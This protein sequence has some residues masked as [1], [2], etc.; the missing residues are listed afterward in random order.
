MAVKP[1]V[2]KSKAKK[3]G[4][5]IGSILKF[6]ESQA[7]GQKSKD[8]FQEAADIEVPPMGAG[9]DMFGLGPQTQ[10]YAAKAGKGVEALAN[11]GLGQLFGTDSAYNLGKPKQSVASGSGNLAN[12]LMSILP[13]G[14]VGA[15]YKAAKK[16]GQM[17]A[18]VAGGMLPN[19]IKNL[20]RLLVESQN[21]K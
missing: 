13:I 2:K 12:V 5:D 4:F 21:S 10:A 11:T 6:I 17:G 20:F 16:T 9:K 1:S 7:V 18:K 15:G 14:G 3:S 19:D 8:L